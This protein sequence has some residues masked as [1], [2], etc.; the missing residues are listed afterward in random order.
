M[1]R[2]DFILAGDRDAV[3][4]APVEHSRHRRAGPGIWF[5]ITD[6]NSNHSDEIGYFQRNAVGVDIGDR[7]RFVGMIGEGRK[8]GREVVREHDGVGDLVGRAVDIDVS[9]S[10]EI[11]IAVEIRPAVLE[12]HPGPGGFRRKRCGPKASGRL[13]RADSA[14]VGRELAGAVDLAEMERV[15]VLAELVHVR[16]KVHD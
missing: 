4:R 10:Q 6:D 2:R 15:V 11:T 8:T 14:A 1:Q 9:E 13:Q 3:V 12:Q 16:R 5:G 7:H